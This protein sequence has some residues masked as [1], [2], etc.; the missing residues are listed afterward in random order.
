[1]IDSS[2]EITVVNDII[3]IYEGKYHT[4]KDYINMCNTENREINKQNIE[5]C[6]ER[7]KCQPF[8]FWHIIPYVRPRVSE[9]IFNAAK[10]RSSITDLS[11][12]LKTFP[13]LDNKENKND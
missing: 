4:Y 11:E 13:K 9:S 3:D 6:K 8:N 10:L 2:F 1:M 12:I 7:N 5:I